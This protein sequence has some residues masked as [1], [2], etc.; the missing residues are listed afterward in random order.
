MDMGP[1]AKVRPKNGS[2]FVLAMGIDGAVSRFG[3]NGY[4]SELESKAVCPSNG[5][6]D[7]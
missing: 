5:V 4:G 7:C 2:G 6:G 3:S 1:L